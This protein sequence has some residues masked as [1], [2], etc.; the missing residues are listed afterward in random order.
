VIEDQ[1]AFT[2]VLELRVDVPGFQQSLEEAGRAWASWLD[3]LQAGLKQAIGS[4]SFEGIHEELAALHAQINVL[5]QD[6]TATAEASADAIMSI[7]DRL[8]ADAQAKAQRQRERATETA[9]VEIEA[10]ES[11]A[12][13]WQNARRNT[14]SPFGRALSDI[15]QVVVRMAEMRLIWLAINGILEAVAST[16]TVPLNA[17]REGAHYIDDVQSSADR[18]TG[19]LA[20][21]VKYAESFRDNFA[22]ASQ[23]SKDVVTALRDIAAQTGQSYEHLETTFRSLVTAGAAYHTSNTQDL[24]TLSQILTITNE[25]VK[26]TNNLRGILSEIP[27][28]LNGT[29]QPGSSFLEVT[30]LTVQQAKELAVQA[31]EHHDLLQRLEPLFAPYLDAT[32]QAALHHR[33]VVA[34]LEEQKQRFEAMAALPVY[35]KI[36]E[37]LRDILDWLNQHRAAVQAIADVLGHAVAELVSFAAQVAASGDSASGLKSLFVDIVVSTAQWV[38]TLELAAKTIGDIKRVWDDD[39]GLFG[40]SE[41]PKKTI[42]DVHALEDDYQSFQKL[43]ERFEQQRQTLLSLLNTRTAP[44]GFVGPLPPG[45]VRDDTPPSTLNRQI[46]GTGT[47]PSIDR[48]PHER[49]DA[50]GQY[51]EEL[52]LVRSYY[53]EFRQTVKDGETALL[54][55]KREAAQAIAQYNNLEIE[56][57]QNAGQRYR[58]ALQDYYGRQIADNKATPAD[59]DNALKQFDATQ[60]DAVRRLKDQTAAANREGEHE[61]TQVAETEAR[62]RLAITHEEA[63]QELA[64]AKEKYAQGYATELQYLTDQE[65]IQKRSHEAEIASLDA[66]LSKVAEG[67][68]R[69][70]QLLAQ[71]AL[72]EQRY[73]G[74]VDQNALARIAASERE[75]QSDRQHT[76][77]RQQAAAANEIIAIET[78]DAAKSV[79]SAYQEVFDI[80]GKQI[81]AKIRETEIEL[82]LADAKMRTAGATGAETEA[83]K[84][85][86][87]QLEALHSEQL[88][89]LSANVKVIQGSAEPTAIKQLDTRAAIENTRDS[90]IRNADFGNM[91]SSEL[92]A[93]NDQLRQVNNM[94]ADATPSMGNALDALQQKLLGFDLGDKLNEAD[95]DVEKFAIGLQAAADAIKS[96]G[97]TVDA[98]KQGGLKG[99]V[100]G[101]VGAGITANADILSEVP[102]VG[103][104]LP[105]IG[106][107]LSFFGGLFTHTAQQIADDVKKAFQATLNEYQNGNATLQ[108][109]IATLERERQQAIVSLSGTKGGHDQLDKL[110]PEFD[111]QISQLQQQQKQIIE[112]F[113]EALQGLETQSTTLQGIQQQWTQIVKTVQ[114]Y[115]SAGGDATNATKYLS[116]SLQQMQTDAQN[117]L[118]EANR[119]AIQDAITLNGLLQQKLQ[120]TEQYNQQVFAV[121][122][123]GS[124]QR[125]QGAITQGEQLAQLAAQYAKQMQDLDEQIGITQQKVTAEGQIFD[126]ATSI[127]DLHR[128]DEQLQLKALEQQIQKWTDL[129]SLVDSIFMQPSGVFTTNNPL[130]T[131]LP[132]IIVN[133]NG[134]ITGVSPLDPSTVGQEIGNSISEQLTWQLRQNPTITP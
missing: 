122:N 24:V 72:A 11:V 54:I 126:L 134:D 6:T 27:R 78:G 26:G 121:E 68:E 31:K 56:D 104:F 124:I 116:Y 25:Q 79:H 101:A 127:A 18:L 97:A 129:K 1:A 32:Q 90:L 66:E 63:A 15:G 125:R 89:N 75:A 47:H 115:L 70:A 83:A 52:A 106:S 58:K 19:T 132:P 67:S 103:Q 13:A 45:V 16:V 4:D 74:Q 33:N 9:N 41:D 123:Q 128:Q 17:L 94:L 23:V 108:E 102:V 51:Q 119:Q 59:R 84:R 87:D 80:R 12:N 130:L 49:A 38:A 92:D 46:E 118:D 22:V 95:S 120:L 34:A 133:I 85:L 91:D 62:S 3:D 53:D 71:K 96:I 113:D 35:E 30:G 99:G 131:N 64:I 57:I 37:F 48:Q 107:L 88:Q 112:N 40:G 29:L 20:A 14:A 50:R 110:L 61:A 82:R 10:A 105:A 21:N 28:L 42:A 60:I 69:H 98:V 114:Q 5:F 36:T 93:F 81:D 43:G 7:T 73:T 76:L 117:Q 109:T 8:D 39:G 111:Q 77:A 55:S 65:A 86:R 2:E 100:A 44:T